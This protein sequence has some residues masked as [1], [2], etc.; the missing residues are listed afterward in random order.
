M[1]RTFPGGAPP[2]P[3]AGEI[4]PRTRALRP[5]VGLSEDECSEARRLRRAGFDVEAIAFTLEADERDV[6][7][8]LA[9]MRTRRSTATRGSLNVTRAAHESVANEALSGEAR[10]QTVDRLLTELTLRRAIA[11]APISRDRSKGG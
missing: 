2:G 8:A 10:W 5:A 4:S 11:G 1:S 7:Q 6:E 9:T 3:H